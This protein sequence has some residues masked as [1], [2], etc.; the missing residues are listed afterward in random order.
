ME[1][2][3]SYSQLIVMNQDREQPYVDWTDQDF[4]R[5]YAETEGTIIFEAI[6][7]YTC[8]IEASVGKH[9]ENA[10]VMRTISVP[11]T[12]G[13]EGV[14]ISSILS[15]KLHIRIPQGEYMLV[16]QATPIEEPTDD[17]LYK[18]RYELF[19]EKE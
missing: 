11:F 15:N 5:G 17:E 2:T 14:F 4:E 9:V 12:V 19:F 1:L 13:N 3:I 10:A 8:E 18:I 16:M 7:D 6:S